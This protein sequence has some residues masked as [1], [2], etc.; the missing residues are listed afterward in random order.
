MADLYGRIDAR[1]TPSA[2]PADLGAPGGVF[3]VGWVGAMPVAGG[4]IKRLDAET[5]EIKRMYVDR[6]WRGRGL[7]RRL[8]DALEGEAVRLGYRRTRLDT[9][10]R[11]PVAQAFYER[12]GYVA[13][14]DYNANPFASFWGEKSLAPRVPRSPA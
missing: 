4:G 14:P 2:T 6:A 3:L 10:P 9:G 7:A 8:L 12:A 1:G 11:Q 13:I 5:G